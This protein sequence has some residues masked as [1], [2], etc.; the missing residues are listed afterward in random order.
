MIAGIILAA[1]QSSRLGRP[2]QLLPLAGEP[3][4]RHTVRRVL[5]SSLDE[6]IVII[7]DDADAVRDALEGLPVQLVTNPRAAEG[8][9]TSVVA[10]I[11]ALLD[12]AGP[13]NSPQAEAV[14]ML[15]GDQPTIDPTLINAV[16]QQ[17]RK[18]DSP[19]VATRYYDIVGSPVLFASSLFPEL[20]QIKGDIGARDIV[21][22]K[23]DA[24]E[25]ATVTID[26]PAPPDVDTND[27][28]QRLLASFKP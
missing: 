21:R 26:D 23:R 24:G 22:A 27:D 6:V 7:G 17:W 13:E 3:M 2:K 19:I 4:I 9:S 18:C 14:V 15:L 5:E 12:N 8:Q 10:G 1:G 16:I 20:L 28:Y 11:T 25:L